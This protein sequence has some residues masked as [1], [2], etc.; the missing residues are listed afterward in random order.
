M[1]KIKQMLKSFILKGGFFLI[2]VFLCNIS[3]TIAQDTNSFTLE[4]AQEYALTHNIN[5]EVEKTDIEIAQEQVKETRGIGLPTVS[6][7][8][9]YQRF[10]QLPINLVPAQFI[11]PMAPEGEFAELQFGT[12]NNLSAS[13]EASQL[14]FNGSYL[15]A[16]EAS[17]NFVNISK[18]ELSQTQTDLKFAVANAYY[19]ALIA[20]EQIKLLENNK[21]N[22]SK[23]L[24]ETEQLNESGFVE[25][26]DVDRLRLTLNNLETQIVSAQRSAVLA[27]NALKFQMGMDE[28]ESIELEEN[29][30][31]IVANLEAV[32]IDTT[33]SPNNRAE[34][35]LLEQQ[36]R[37][38]ELDIKNYRWQ[39]LPNLAAF[40]SYQQT[41]QNDKFDVFDDNFWF[42]TFVVGLQLNIPILQGFSKNAQIRQR[43][44]Q[45]LQIRKGKEFLQQ[46]FEL[47]IT[48]AKIN[49]TNALEQV[50]SQKENIELAEKIYKTATI[51]YNEG[52]GSSIE[53]NTAEGSLLETQAL[54]I[55]SLLNLVLAKTNLDK[56]LGKL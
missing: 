43:E 46:S 55:Q 34:F 36:E 13:I 49:F 54:Y 15:V 26:L 51:K 9:N 29:F 37:L 47:E 6:A 25:A 45:A 35:R 33:F 10:V 53:V 40:A 11:N 7:G 41:F 14:I 1:R 56:A 23:I 28:G 3:N 39:R 2:M 19:N 42:P 38:N 48:Q 44:I 31:D 32:A 17:R 4:S 8:L 22:L 27:K 50:K 5:I 20:Q 24:F 18:E 12:K 30:Q 21:E 16:L 52:I